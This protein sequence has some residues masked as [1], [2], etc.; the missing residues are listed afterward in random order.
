[1]GLARQHAALSDELG[2]AFKRVVDTDAFILGREVEAFEREFADYCEAS[3]CVGVA[4]GTAALAL[5]LTA[6]GIGRGDEVVVPGH[7]FIASA[8]SVLHAGATPVFCDVD[9]DTG[10]LDPEAAAAVI[11]E[12]TAAI[13]AV[14]LYGQ[15]CETGPIK[16]LVRQRG[17][18]RAGPLCG[19][20]PSG[21]PGRPS[22]PR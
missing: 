17:P 11:G 8:L 2:A 3:E 14:H 21:R 1:V 9:Q 16:A 5:V 15:A 4:S 12:R 18:A 13:M 6:A 20:G 19:A 22:G 10:L 7:T